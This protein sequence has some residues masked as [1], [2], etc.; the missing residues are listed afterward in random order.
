MNPIRPAL[1]VSLV[2]SALLCGCGEQEL[3][4]QLSERQANEMVALLRGA[5]VDARAR[6]RAISRC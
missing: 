3:Y 4:T 1:V 5:G 6:R 2:L